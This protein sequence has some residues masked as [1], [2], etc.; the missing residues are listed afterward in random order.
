M[1]YL[2]SF[3]FL[4][5]F[6]LIAFSLFAND[7]NI[8]DKGAIIHGFKLKIIEEIKDINSTVR[9]FEHK[10][11]KARLVYISNDDKNKFFSI[12]FKTLPENNK[13]V[14]HILEHSVLRGS[15]KYPVKSIAG[16]LR[17]GSL[18]TFIN[19][20]TYSDHT[21]YPVASMNDT[22]FKNMMTVYLD[23]VFHPLAL[24]NENIFLQEGWRYLLDDQNNKLSYN[25]IVYNE[26]KGAMSDPKRQLFTDNFKHLYSGTIY[27]NESGGLPKDIPNLSYKEFKNFHEKYYHPSNSYIF[28]YGN[29]DIANHLSIINDLY[30][31]KFDKKKVNSKI[32]MNLD[33]NSFKNITEYYPINKSMPTKDNTFLS[34]G[35]LID[36]NLDAEDYYG[37][38]ILSY[39]LCNS[40]SSPLRKAFTDAKIGKD[41]FATAFYEFKNPSFFIVSKNANPEDKELFL[42]LVNS[43]LT[44]LY[45]NGID[46]KLLDAAINAFQF[47]KKSEISDNTQIGLSYMDSC[48]STWLFGKD[49]FMTLRIEKVFNKIKQLSKKAYFEK[50]I[51]KY[52]IK[53]KKK[54]L[55]SLI[56]KQ[57]LNEELELKEKNKLEKILKNL[58]KEEISKI[59]KQTSDLKKYQETKD[60]PEAL[61]SIPRISISDIDKETEII[62]QEIKDLPGTKVLFHPIFTNNI[63]YVDF[64]IDASTLPKDLIHYGIFYLSILGQIDTIN[65]SYI[66]FNN[67]ADTYTGGIYSYL[68]VFTQNESI[69]EFT[70]KIRFGT[71]FLIE[72]IDK[73]FALL[74]EYALMAKIEDKARI[75]ALLKEKISGL[76]SGISRGAIN[77]GINKLVG[78]I[79]P[80]MKYVDKYDLYGFYVFAK[81]LLEN[82]DKNADEVINKLN[83]VSK[84]IFHKNNLLISVT[85]DNKSY[86]L[87]EK[88]I[89]AVLK[90]LPLIK[91]KKEKLALT[92]QS[93][94]YGLIIP[95]N[96][97]YVMQA[98]NIKKHGFMPNGHLDV[99]INILKNDYLYEKIRV[100]GG[101]YGSV[102][103]YD[104]NGVIFLFSYRDPHILKTYETYKGIDDYMNFLDLSET[105][106][107]NYIISTIS[108]EDQPLSPSQKGRKAT[109]MYLKGESF[110]ENQKY[111][112]EI[113]STKLND[114]KSFKGLFKNI[115]N[116]NLI[117]TI[118]G[119]AKINENAK[120]FDE[121]IYLMGK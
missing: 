44:D 1:K 52:F 80:G 45:K 104:R 32:K 106:L 39:L 42:K 38:V 54:V 43:T 99:L 33:Y 121:I 103:D 65:S 76:E 78:N 98:G 14:A 74:K 35:Y 50:L 89:K 49:P 41:M 114:L 8:N 18:S 118:G 109:A 73:A 16:E 97:Q 90:D 92:G 120:L 119:E 59:K 70:P 36:D 27:A 21:S 48:L 20:M 115:N 91:A 30:L 3:I 5:C 69:E 112:D 22:E 85:S 117:L 63:G 57:G 37:L 7:I 102:L 56:P 51:K 94:N 110:N 72:N 26:M 64:L 111:R 101:A 77:F 71:S 68:K 96:V 82:Y 19:A 47:S 29:G 62:P 55:L 93:K 75:K 83:K 15:K 116:E 46:E 107:Q 6:S 10:Q 81:N 9:L 24:E 88:N 79:C 28:L 12:T 25:G 108:S 2:K 87:F 23:T 100:L 67:K 40:E 84:L 105:E 66:D 61:A 34:L 11:T 31:S 58:N 4:S 13:G 95:S 113:I 17:K 86:T 53:N 60:S